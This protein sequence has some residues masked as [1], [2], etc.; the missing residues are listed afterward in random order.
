M[1]CCPSP[2]RHGRITCGV[3]RR[4]ERPHQAQGF[5]AE[6]LHLIDQDMR[7]GLKIPMFDR[8]SRLM[9]GAIEGEQV[10]LVQATL[11]HPIRYAHTWRRCSRVIRGRPERTA[12][13]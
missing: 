7:V 3:G 13:R 5:Q 9:N 8:Q 6:I 1:R 2:T 12:V 4:A 11:E 10:A